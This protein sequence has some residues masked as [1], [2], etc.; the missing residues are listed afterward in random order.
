MKE[1]SLENIL[2]QEYASFLTKEFLTYAKGTQYEV[3]FS[4]NLS[5]IQASKTGNLAIPFSEKGPISDILFKRRDNLLYFSKVF[6]QLTTVENGFGN[7]LKTGTATK[8]EKIQEVLKEL[9]STNPLSIKKG[10]KEYVLC[11]EGEQK[12]ALEKALSHPFFVLTGGPGT[13]KTTVVA[14]V[15]RGLLR[16][17]YDLK[18][19]GLAA[20]TGRAAQRLKESLENTI[21][22]LRTKN[23]L[24]DSIS[25]IPTSTLHRLLEYNPRKRKYKYGKNFP[26]PYRVI[27]LDEVSMVDLHMMYRLMEAL[28]LGLENFRFIL[29]GDPNQLPSVE[30]GAILSDLVI[31]LKKLNSENLIELKTSHRQEEEFSSISKAAEICVKDNIS[32]SEFQKNLPKSLHID[33]VF[34]G[35]S[36]EDLKGF[37]Q[38]RLDYKK[39]WKEFLK[40]TAEEKILPIFSKLPNPNSPKELKEY[41]N[42]DLNRFKILTILRN[43]IFGSE[44]INKELTELILHHKKGNLVQIGTKTYF[45]GLPILI[46][47]N[48][49]VRGVYNGDTGLVLEVQTPNGGSE[50][51]AL[52]FIEGEIRDFAL[53]TLPPHEPAFAI[54]VH[55]S[56]GSEYD[57]VFIIYP[58]DP[59]EPDTAE[60]SLELFKK[61]ILYT[62]ITRAKRSAFLVSEEKLLE[63]SLRNRFERLTGFKLG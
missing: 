8:P 21:S 29:L 39:E 49:R 22:N 53:D 5:L 9:I 23:K 27:I 1:E 14:N 52:F 16:L 31:S 30:A 35:P 32:L 62:A 3:L 57:S 11:G 36:K 19:I 63:Y 13:G 37:Y 42:K 15:I 2:D 7:L 45:S 55:K 48:D 58:P 34:L 25:E 4:W 56:Q 54:T 51:R 61:E 59:V 18:Q 44:F 38:I 41:L 20:P 46:T 6:S 50:L 60:V 33:S 17:G 40:R 10:G 28:P 12:D 26:L 47:K 43:G 24:D